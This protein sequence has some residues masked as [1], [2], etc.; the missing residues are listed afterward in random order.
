MST[1]NS[2]EVLK[3]E[4]QLLEAQVGETYGN[5]LARHAPYEYRGW[6]QSA[7]GSYCKKTGWP[8]LGG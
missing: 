8:Q 1:G 5:L 3:Y 2:M 6:V 4:K 7:T